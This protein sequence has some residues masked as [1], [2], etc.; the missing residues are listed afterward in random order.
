MMIGRRGELLADSEV[1]DG[2]VI[3]I[4][5]EY[6]RNLQQAPD[7]VEVWHFLLRKVH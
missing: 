1:T 3:I 4:P 5:R 2:V 6:P 7:Q